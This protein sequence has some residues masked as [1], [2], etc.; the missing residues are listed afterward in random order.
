[1]ILMLK[2]MSKVVFMFS[3]LVEV[4]DDVGDREHQGILEA[5]P[6]LHPLLGVGVLIE[7][8]IKFLCTQQ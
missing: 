8:V 1:M 4:V 6:E 3:V 7:E 2:N 5:S